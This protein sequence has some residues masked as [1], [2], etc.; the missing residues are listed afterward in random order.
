MVERKSI[1]ATGMVVSDSMDG[2]SF[3]NYE[4]DNG[5]LVGD[6][7]SYILVIL[8]I[9]QR[10]NFIAKVM[11]ISQINVLFICPAGRRKQ[12]LFT[13]SIIMRFSWRLIVFLIV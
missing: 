5:S 11:L 6:N 13:I 4:H 10:D 2:V 8:I 3:Q 7:V 9:A 12:T 1:R